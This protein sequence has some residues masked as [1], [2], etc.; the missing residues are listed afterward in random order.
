MVGFVNVEIPLFLIIFLSS[1]L[2]IA[3]II[4]VRVQKIPNLLTFPAM[5]MALIFHSVTG[6]WKGFVFSA[7]GLGLGIALFLIP[8]IM[9][10]MVQEMPNSWVRLAQLLA[11]KAYF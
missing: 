6:G 2:I 11:L 3:A 4:D 5:V 10:G 7:E 8:Y 9:G 1:I